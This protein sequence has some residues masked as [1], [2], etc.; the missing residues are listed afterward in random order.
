M[1]ASPK[2]HCLLQHL[3]GGCGGDIWCKDLLNFPMNVGAGD[4]EATGSLAL[5]LPRL[6]RA[7]DGGV[8]AV[9]RASALLP[10]SRCR[11]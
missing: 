4:W 1:M 7:G 9:I 5:A 6:C 10:A 3:Q 8:P 2:R 11:V